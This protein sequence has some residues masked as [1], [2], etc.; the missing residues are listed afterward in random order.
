MGENTNIAWAHHSFNPWIGCTKVSPACEHCYAEALDRRWG[1]DSWGSGK[2]RRRT[3]E[4]NWRKPLKWNRKAEAS[5]EVCRVFCGSLCDVFD[6]EVPAAWRADL[7]NLIRD[8]PNLTWMLLTKRIGNA[9]KMLPANWG[10]GYPNVWLGA[11]IPNQAEADRDIPKLNDIA[12]AKRFISYEPALGP[13]F[14]PRYGVDW[15]ICGGESGPGA[16]MMHP[17]WARSVRDQCAGENGAG[18]SFFFKQ[19]GA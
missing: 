16:R 2:P 1:H 18:V 11:T 13:L 9:A 19:W 4:A 10:D 14:V 3:S 7:F 12:A 5:G 15:I 17:E 8:T 6:N